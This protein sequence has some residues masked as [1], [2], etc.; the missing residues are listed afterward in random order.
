MLDY[1]RLECAVE[2]GR[3]HTEELT[4]PHPLTLL[5]I[6]PAEAD[7]RIVLSNGPLRMVLSSNP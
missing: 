7:P 5:S 1:Y 3:E 6:H 4:T 2:I